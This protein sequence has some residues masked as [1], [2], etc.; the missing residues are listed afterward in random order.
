M[1]SLQLASSVCTLLAE[2]KTTKRAAPSASA[3]WLK[4]LMIAC[5]TGLA[6][7]AT[8]S[9]TVTSFLAAAPLAP[10]PIANALATIAATAIA[11]NPLRAFLISVPPGAPDWLASNQPE[12]PAKHKS[13]RAGRHRRPLRRLG[14]SPG[15]MV[16]RPRV[17]ACMRRNPDPLNRFVLERRQYGFPRRHARRVAAGASG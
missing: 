15:K 2:S 9:A 16:E 17:S 13:L 10:S 5:S 12:R 7:I 3:T 4:A 8:K 14:Q 6:W 11:R 1:A